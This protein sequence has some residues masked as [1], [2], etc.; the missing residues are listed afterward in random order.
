MMLRKL[1]G[2]V[3][4][5]ALSVSASSVY[6]QGQT[7]DYTIAPGDLDD[8]GSAT[9]NTAFAFD[10]D[11]LRP[12]GGGTGAPGWGASSFYS[13]VNGSLDP[14]PGKDYTALRLNIENVFQS[15]NPM[16]V[17]EIADISWWTKNEVVGGR[18]WQI[19][20]YTQGPSASIWYTTR[21]NINHGEATD[22]N[23]HQWS[24]TANG[25]SS[26]HDKASNSYLPDNDSN[27]E[28]SEIIAAYGAEEIKYID[29]IAGYATASP[30]VNSFLDGITIYRDNGDVA[31]IDLV[32]E[33][34][35]LLL[36]ILGGF[37]AMS[38]RRKA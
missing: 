35:S 10:W 12:D 18:D 25:V 16:T 3:V 4:V 33:P 24:M 26:I 28:W 37:M 1:F 14:A 20:V 38:R 36:L 27:D 22:T 17:S 15:A 31:N 5:G 32:P 34:A 13:N 9:A 19:K 29:V 7:Y 6:A 23:W 2:L 8:A 30:P 11:E 21:I